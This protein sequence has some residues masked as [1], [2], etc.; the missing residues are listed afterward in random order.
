MAA[1]LERG[2][3]G[4]GRAGNKGAR[5]QTV[6]P[7]GPPSLR[8]AGRGGAGA[9]AGFSG[10]H[11]E[12]PLTQPLALRYRRNLSLRRK[13]P[14]PGRPRLGPQGSSFG[15]KCP[16]GLVVASGP[17]RARESSGAS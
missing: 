5:R 6:A 11:P 10:S 2:V 14:R 12:R 9:G 16:K 3:G 4:G 7:G 15:D 1:R 13:R 8:G 17:R